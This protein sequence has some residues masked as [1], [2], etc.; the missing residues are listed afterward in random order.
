MKQQTVYLVYHSC[1][2]EKCDLYGVY[3]N[4]RLARI[5]AEGFVDSPRIWMGASCV[6]VG[7]GGWSVAHVEEWQVRGRAARNFEDSD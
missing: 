2:P 6:H 4:E 1:A 7:G 5:A 3:A